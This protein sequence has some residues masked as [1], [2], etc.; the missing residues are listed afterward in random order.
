MELRIERKYKKKGYTI[1]KL[2]INNEYFCDTLEDVVRDLKSDGSGKIKNETA[3]PKGTYKVILNYS[4]KFKRVLPLILSVPFF[5]GIRIHRGNKPS[6]TSGCVLVGLNKVKGGLVESAS[7]E[8]RLCE[9]L[10]NVK[11]DIWLRIVE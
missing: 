6:D 5:E 3:I 1:G 9:K 8:I 10:K 11:E 2:F 4:P 7:C